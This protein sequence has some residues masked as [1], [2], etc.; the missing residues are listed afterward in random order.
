MVANKSVLQ[1]WVWNAAFD[2]RVCMSCIVMH[3][4]I[5][6]VEEPL[7]DHHNGRCVA[8][9]LVIG[10]PN[11]V[12][13]TGEQWFARQSEA[14]Q[15]SL[16]GREYYDAWRGGAFDLSEMSTTHRD[17]VY[18]D[19][20]VQARLWQLLGAEPPVSVEREAVGVQ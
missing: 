19:M 1:G 7:N 8:I 17:E 9:P 5:H 16:M 14:T 2:D 3:G 6:P 18:G 20:R 13:E 12:T 10:F 11:P 4:T 15:R